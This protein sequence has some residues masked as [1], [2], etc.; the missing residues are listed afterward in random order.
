[1]KL[2]IKTKRLYITEFDESMA[3]SVHINSLDEDNRRFIPDE[4]FETV[5]DAQDTLVLLMAYYTQNDK[6]L[7]YPVFLHDGEQIGHVQAIPVEDGWE[8]GYH[9]AKA[10]TNNGYATEALNAFLPPVMELLN[11][12][13][14]YGI[15]HAKNI[16]SRRILEKCGF[17]LKYEGTGILHKKQQPVC[18]Y[19]KHFIP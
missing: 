3:E 11:I 19:K 8:V 18:K 2:P 7:V 16:A 14:I 10:H 17:I 1:M 9:I 5:S 4:V 6:P 15:C 12:S 13:H